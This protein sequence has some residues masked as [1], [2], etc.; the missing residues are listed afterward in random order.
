MRIIIETSESEERVLLRPEDQPMTH[1]AAGSE[2]D[3]TDAGPPHE[4]LMQ[5]LNER[6][7]APA[8]SRAG[9]LEEPFA[10][11]MTGG[12]PSSSRH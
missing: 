12:E 10:M 11:V 4:D 1:R 7:S 9:A 6:A 5:A 2:P 3:A 8:A